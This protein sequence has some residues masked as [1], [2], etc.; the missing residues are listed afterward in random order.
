MIVYV[1]LFSCVLMLSIGQVLFK[2]SAGLLSTL[3]NP[4]LLVFEPVFLGALFLYGIATICWIG[5]LQFLPLGRAYMFMSLAFIIVPLL[6]WY[7][8]DETLEMRF[9]FGTVLIVSGVL[10]TLK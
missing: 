2:K 7:F 6:G 3:S 4:L 8:F 5:A 10:L 9:V 1:F